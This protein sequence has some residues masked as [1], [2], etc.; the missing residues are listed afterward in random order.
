MNTGSGVL[1]IS[2]RRYAGAVP[3][4]PLPSGID[5]RPQMAIPAAKMSTGNR[6]TAALR[7]MTPGGVSRPQRDFMQLARPTTGY[8][9]RAADGS[10]FR[11]T[12]AISVFAAGPEEWGF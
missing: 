2:L 9:A 5:A 3:L 6:P 1:A 11:F 8:E 12:A 4:A 7:F 10:A